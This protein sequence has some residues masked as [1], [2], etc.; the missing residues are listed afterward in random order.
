MKT[1]TVKT[2]YKA[3]KAYIR[4]AKYDFDGSLAI[5]LVDA[6]DGSPLARITVCLVDD[7]GLPYLCVSEDTAF[8]DTNNYPWAEDFIVSNGLGGPAG[9]TA[10]SGFCTYPLY[11]FDL[12]KLGA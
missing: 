4:T 6:K 8:V 1:Y 7:L 10:R 9:R 12:K 2:D 5:Q 3:Y 11:K